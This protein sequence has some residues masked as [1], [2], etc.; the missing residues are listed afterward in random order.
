M[1][2]TA[3]RNMQENRLS[4]PRARTAADK[5]IERINS[6]DLFQQMR[7]VEI[8]HEGRIYRLRLTQLNKLI[9]TA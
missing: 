8:A 5:P 9:L 6:R 1:T 4:A 2:I 3:Q 7:E